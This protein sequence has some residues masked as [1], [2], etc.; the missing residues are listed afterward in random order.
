MT[1]QAITETRRRP[2]SFLVF[3]LIELMVVIAIIA[4]LATLLLPALKN[5]RE[6][7]KRIVC[8][9]NERQIFQSWMSYCE[10]NSGGLPCWDSSVWNPPLLPHK[11]WIVVMADWLSPAT[12]Y[13]NGTEYIAQ[14][15]ILACPSLSPRGSSGSAMDFNYPDYG[16]YRFGIGGSTANGAK[17]YSR[18]ADVSAPSQLVG[19]GDAYIPWSQPSAIFGSYS[20]GATINDNNHFRH[21]SRTNLLFADGHS[22]PKD[23]S[24]FNPA[25]GWWNVA[26][27]GN[28]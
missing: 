11:H 4:I 10:D 18:M 21:S 3:T 13:K 17:K 24:F 1:R 27:W 25:W 7:A 12:F 6:T 9:G 5:A 20:F 8:V 22:E 28:P 15:S 23:R 14:N 26:P 2:C 16:M 19:F